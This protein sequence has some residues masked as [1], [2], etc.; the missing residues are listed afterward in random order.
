MKFILLT[1]LIFMM[2]DFTG[3]AQK[4][5]V[6]LNINEIKGYLKNGGNLN[7]R[8]DYGLRYYQ[9]YIHHFGYHCDMDELPIVRY[10]FQQ[11]QKLKDP[12]WFIDD[13]C[14]EMQGYIFYYIQLVKTNNRYLKTKT[15]IDLVNFYFLSGDFIG[16]NAIDEFDIQDKTPLMY[17]CEF[18]NKKLIKYLLAHDANPQLKNKNNQ[19]AADFCKNKSHRKLVE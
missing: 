3:S 17:A 10:L 19:T 16:F 5:V 6:D 1:A 9:G 8:E 15:I 4:S 11:N 13:P 18:S 12:F 14:M 7:S 2:T